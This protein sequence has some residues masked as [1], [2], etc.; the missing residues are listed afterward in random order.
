MSDRPTDGP[1]HEWFSPSYSNYLVLHRSHL[2]SMPIEF[3]KRMV[4]CLEELQAAFAHTEQPECFD[5]KAAT[6]HEVWELSEA[7]LKQAG[8]TADWYRGETPPEGWSEED[9]AEW[10]AEHESPEGPTY[11]R[12]GEEIDGDEHVLLP[13]IDPVPH[14]NRGRTYIE[15]R[16]P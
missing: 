7:E 2:Q 15:P 5:V 11:S 8:I 16:T 10:R 12:N 9:L 14:Y 4:A 6:E 3:Q 13:A 1:I